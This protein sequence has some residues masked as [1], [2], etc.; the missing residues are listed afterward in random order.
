MGLGTQVL[1]DAGTWDSRMQGRGMR[2]R[3]DMGT[4]DTK[5]LGFGM[6]HVGTRGRDKQTPEKYLHILGMKMKEIL[7]FGHWLS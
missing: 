4:W 6:W 5:T 7:I 1:G 2:G 3:W